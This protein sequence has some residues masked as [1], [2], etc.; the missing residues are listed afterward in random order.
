MGNPSPQPNA[1]S[2]RAEL[3]RLNSIEEQ[4]KFAYN[5]AI[6]NDCAVDLFGK[7]AS[8]KHL[9]LF[10]SGNESENWIDVEQRIVYKMNTL[11]HV[12]ENIARLLLRVDLYNKLFPSTKLTFVGFQ[13]F[14]TTHVCPVFAQTF[15]DDARFATNEEIHMYME[16]MDFHPTSKDGEFENEDYVLS[17][18]RPKN[19]LV[20]Y[21][22]AIVVI[23]ADVVKK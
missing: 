11:M 5:W 13:L 17:D 21:S 10:K 23:D 3:E 22:G 18:I 12:G 4:H 1:Q 7:F 9:I 20:S 15:I 6:E 2:L 14:S 16:L 19:V 8:E